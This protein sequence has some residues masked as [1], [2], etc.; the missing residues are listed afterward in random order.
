M[1]DSLAETIFQNLVREGLIKG[2][3][4]PTLTAVQRAALIWSVTASQNA[5]SAGPSG[6]GSGP[7]TAGQGVGTT[8]GQSGQH[9]YA[10]QAG[11]GLIYGSLYPQTDY[12]TG[13]PVPDTQRSPTT[14]EVSELKSEVASLKEV[15]TT[16]SAFVAQQRKEL[17]QIKALISDVRSRQTNGA[18]YWDES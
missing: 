8:I 11:N 16:L 3:T 1:S 10:N 15:V 13:L 7:I 12:E 18:G 5:S 9:M 17:D 2:I 14:D 6:P 4:N